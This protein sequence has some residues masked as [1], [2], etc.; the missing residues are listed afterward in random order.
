MYGTYL[1][2][3][4]TSSAKVLKWSV[5]GTF[6]AQYVTS[7]PAAEG[8]PIGVAIDP[9]TNDLWLA[10]TY[11]DRLV[12]LAPN[13]TQLSVISGL[14][15]PTGLAFSPMGVLYIAQAGGHLILRK[16]ANGTLSPFFNNTYIPNQITFDWLGNLYISDDLNRIL[17]VS[18]T[19]VLLNQFTTSSP[20]LSGPRGVAVDSL[21][22]LYV[23][24]SGNDRIVV[25]PGVTLPT[26]QSSSA[27]SPPTPSPSSTAP[28]APSSYPS[29]QLCSITYGLPGTVDYPWS[30][31][32]T[33]NFVYNPNPITTPFGKAVSIV[34]AAG[35]RTFTNR[36][37]VSSSTPFNVVIQNEVFGGDVTSAA[38]VY[39]DSATPFDLNGLTWSLSS[40]V[41][42]PG[43]SASILQS[44]LRVY[45]LSGAVVEANSGGVGLLVDA[46]SQAFLSNVPGFP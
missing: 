3:E 6:I 29:G 19:G 38:Y 10:D 12:Q 27:A 17:Q 45:N 22:N 2:E 34:S 44:T 5:K 28:S 24:D 7:S 13:G 26:P 36:F 4:R 8:A 31:A 21:G 1:N 25:F 35:T 16:S 42:L 32:S 9:S 33:L 39:L 18:P 40:A 30:V 23:A 46:M 37:G 11:N 41:Q 43:L 20:A 15:A 14:G